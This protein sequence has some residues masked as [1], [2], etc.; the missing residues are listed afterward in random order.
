MSGTIGPEGPGGEPHGSPRRRVSP[1]RQRAAV[2]LSTRSR[3]ALRRSIGS[4]ALFAIVY[5][6]TASAVYFGLGVIA[7]HALGL[8]PLVFLLAAAMFVPTAMTYLEGA[9]LHPERGGS[10]VFARYAFN[11]LVS[12]VAGWAMLLDYVILIAVTA[13]AA[14]QYL[15]VF[16]APLAGNL[17]AIGLA[18]ALIAV[19]VLSS[20]RGFA[21]RREVRIGALVL[22]AVLVLLL[23]V[24]IGLA[25][26][27]HPSRMVR[28][29][30]L[31]RTPTWSG[32]VFALTI[33][34]IAFTGVESASGIAS[35]VRVGLAGLKRLLSAGSVLL[36]VCYLGIGLLAASDLHAAGGAHVGSGGISLGTSFTD[37]PMIGLV[38]QMHPQLLRQ[39]MRNVVAA[40]AASTLFAAANAAMLG[41]SR[42]GYTLSTNRQ[43][44]SGLGRLHPRRATPHLIILI[45]GVLAFCLVL[46]ENLELLVGL[47]AFGAALAF[48]IA[49]VSV[50]RLRYRERDRPRPYAIPL[51][52]SFRGASLPLPAAAGAV[53]FAAAWVAVMVVHLYA[54]YVGLGWIVLGLALYVRY[55]RSAELPLLRRVAV[56]PQMLS[57]EQPGERDYSSI[58]VPLSGT[59]IDD[60][61]IQTAALLA[62][63]QPT[64]EGEPCSTIEAVWIFE[65]PMLLPLDARLPEEQIRRA[66][67]ALARAK[68]V[69]EEY[70][71]VQVATATVRARRVGEAIVEE[72][73]RRGV[74]AIVLS[75]EEP[76]KVR[77]G[78]RLGGRAAPI[79]N[80]V[81]EAARYV[82]GK[83]DCRVILTA[84]PAREASAEGAA[85]M[86]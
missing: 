69:G 10:S 3:S 74:E 26:I 79:E 16:W 2:E 5:A 47:Y 30:S 53:L 55:R 14:T 67:Q 78:V 25:T 71:G 86:G 49:H 13:Y 31:G 35:E 7:S 76:S 27:F 28:S 50:C 24:G 11:E 33:T 54:R 82:I 85:A 60:D 77:G 17:E 65:I 63:G 12:F 9:L 62:S 45:A 4:P 38:S 21:P 44:P 75:A 52:V 66:R 83:A 58:L 64:E 19:V 57:A 6:S 61:I 56:A 80:H 39:V 32:L 18:A 1:A 23:V 68:A 8:T 59:S 37:T 15:G 42:L 70:A 84:P 40:V 29:I 43:V 46:P 72:S 81:G 48:T 73:R 34:T 20:I 22:V 41:L 51:S 36:L